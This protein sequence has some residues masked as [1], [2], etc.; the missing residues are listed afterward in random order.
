VHELV[1]GWKEL[2]CAF[3]PFT[4]RF[5]GLLLAPDR[6]P[7]D[8]LSSVDVYPPE[9]APLH[10]NH[11]SHQYRACGSH[12]GVAREILLTTRCQFFSGAFPPLLAARTLATLARHL[13]LGRE[14]YAKR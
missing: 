10:R 7:S 4:F 9:R 1:R 3:G 6:L 13:L 12:R 2:L 5:P 14:A 8:T 11:P